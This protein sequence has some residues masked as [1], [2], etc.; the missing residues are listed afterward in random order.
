MNHE[1][2]KRHRTCER[3]TGRWVGRRDAN[4]AALIAWRH[5]KFRWPYLCPYCGQFHLTSQRQGEEKENTA[6]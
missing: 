2:W 1:A 6:T 5:G 4:W 3:K